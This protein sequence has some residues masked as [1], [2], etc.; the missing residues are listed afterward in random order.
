MQ[1]KIMPDGFKIEGETFFARAI[2]FLDSV[3]RGI[4]QVFFQSNTYAGVLFF[5]RNFL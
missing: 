5:V 1:I 3:F 4:G 2:E